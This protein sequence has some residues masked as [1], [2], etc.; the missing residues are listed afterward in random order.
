MSGIAL[1]FARLKEP[2]PGYGRI[3]LL[4]SGG[5]LLLVALGAFLRRPWT[6]RWA[7]GIHVTILAAGVVATSVQVATRE[8]SEN[9]WWLLLTRLSALLLYLAMALFWMRRDVKAELERRA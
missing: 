6:R 5:L 9:L 1:A 2:L 7:L 3:L 8:A 4:V